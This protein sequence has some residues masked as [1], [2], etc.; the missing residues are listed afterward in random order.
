MLAATCDIVVG[1]DTTSDERIDIQLH[2]QHAIPS[3]VSADEARVRVVA[4]ALEEIDMRVRNL[5]FPELYSGA[6]L[7]VQRCD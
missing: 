5:E 4:C 6:Y 1:G 2:K 7:R 3:R